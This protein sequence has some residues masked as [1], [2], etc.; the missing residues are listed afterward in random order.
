MEV[1]TVAEARAGLSRALAEFRRDGGATPLL[2]G[3]HRRAEA[4][5]IPL[6]QYQRLTSRADPVGLDRLRELGSII[7]RLA[8]VSHLRDVRVFG[9]VARGEQD[10]D[11]DVDLLVTADPEAT[12]FD[13]AQ[14]EMDLETILGVPVTA[15]TSA[16]LDERRD[17]RILAEAV[18]L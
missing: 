15:V 4:V 8:R 11:S 1:T 3:S 12:M 14:F 7:D 16:S 5:L 18:A 13:V 10:A 6:E 2:I 17:A 9:S